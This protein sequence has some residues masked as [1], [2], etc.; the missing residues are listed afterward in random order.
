MFIDGPWLRGEKLDLQ[1]DV[2]LQILPGHMCAAV[3][4][5]TIPGSANPSGYVYVG[6]T[7]KNYRI[8]DIPSKMKDYFLDPSFY[9]KKSF[10]VEI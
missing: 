1:Y 3:K 10:T 9:P 6:T 5:Q 4:A 8:G 2:A 7:A